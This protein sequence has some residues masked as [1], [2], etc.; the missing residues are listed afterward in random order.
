METRDQQRF[1]ENFANT[2]H[3]KQSSILY[4]QSLLN[5]QT[6]KQQSS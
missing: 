3:Y 4:M 1:K 2:K 6:D 5:E